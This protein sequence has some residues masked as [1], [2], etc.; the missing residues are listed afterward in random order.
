EAVLSEQ[1]RIAVLRQAEIRAREVSMV[2]LLI[3]FCQWRYPPPPRA[4]R[5]EAAAIRGIA[6]PLPP[7][8]YGGPVPV[9]S[10]VSPGLWSLTPKP[11]RRTMMRIHSTAFP[12]LPTTSIGVRPARW[13]STR[14]WRLRR[15]LTPIMLRRACTPR[16]SEG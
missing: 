2:G 16:R 1:A 8:Q 13:T 3:E 12:G 5:E 9:F 6:P 15:S 11:R 14:P 4:L 7:C 10:P